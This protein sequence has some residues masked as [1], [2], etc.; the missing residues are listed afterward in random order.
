MS[1]IDYLRQ[2][3]SDPHFRQSDGLAVD[4]DDYRKPDPL[5]PGTIAKMEGAQFLGLGTQEPQKV[6]KAATPKPNWPSPTS[7]R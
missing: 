2:F 5:P 4:T 7:G 3:F 1:L 6:A